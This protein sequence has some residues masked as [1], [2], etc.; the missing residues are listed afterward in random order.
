M[1]DSDYFNGKKKG[2][3]NKGMGN[4]CGRIE[5]RRLNVRKE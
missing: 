5:G 3:T 4:K 1:Y 2:Q